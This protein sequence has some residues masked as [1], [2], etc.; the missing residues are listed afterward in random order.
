MCPNPSGSV[1]G[2]YNGQINREYLRVFGL[3]RQI[4]ASPRVLAD[5]VRKYRSPVYVAGAMFAQRAIKIVAFIMTDFD[6]F[7]DRVGQDEPTTKPCRRWHAYPK[8]FGASNGGFDCPIIISSDPDIRTE[9]CGNCGRGMV[10]CD[11]ERS[12]L[13]EDSEADFEVCVRSEPNCRHRQ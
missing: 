2:W 11:C 13:D 5:T 8:G 7:L 3:S 1:D 10:V 6:E 12:D 4:Q 9:P